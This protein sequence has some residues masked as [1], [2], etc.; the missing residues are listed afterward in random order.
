MCMG[1]AWDGGTAGSV[2]E[3]TELIGPENIVWAKGLPRE[4]MDV[5]S[6][7][8][9]CGVDVPAS[10]S[11]VGVNVVPGVFDYTPPEWVDD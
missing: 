8:C 6:D 1:V 11:R 5:R 7:F 10:L 4:C 2:S 9:L 3:L